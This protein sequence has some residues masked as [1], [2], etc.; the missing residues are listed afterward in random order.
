MS[1][2]TIDKDSGVIVC[3]WLFYEEGHID[4]PMFKVRAKSLWEAQRIAYDEFGPQVEEL[5][6]KMIS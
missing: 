6:Y 4:S 2:S 1:V 3:E 5:M